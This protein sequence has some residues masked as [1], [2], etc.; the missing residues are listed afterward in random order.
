MG[1]SRPD[2]DYP[3][4]IAELR[5]KAVRIGAELAAMKPPP[6]LAKT[7]QRANAVRRALHQI[8]HHNTSVAI[9]GGFN[10]GKTLVVS[11][12]LGLSELL[13]VRA[14]AAT[15]NITRMRLRPGA[16]PAITYA[17]ITLMP[18]EIVAEMVE[19]VIAG[20]TD[21]VGTLPAYAALRALRGTPIVDVDDPAETDWS[22]LESALAQA[23][24]APATSPA[25]RNATVELL[26]IRNALRVAGR[27][28][29][30]R[31]PGAE[32][33]IGLN[34]LPAALLIE[35]SRDISDDPLGA[36]APHE[37]IGGAQLSSEAG[38]RAVFPLIHEVVVDVVVDP[39]VWSIAD[40][41]TDLLDLPGAGAS[42]KHDDFLIDLAIAQATVVAFM[43]DAEN[44]QSDRVV[45]IHHALEKGRRDRRA[46][47]ASALVLANR[48]DRVNPPVQPMNSAAQ[49]GAH[50][51]VARVLAQVDALAGQ[52]YE[53]LV[54]LSALGAAGERGQT[55]PGAKAKDQND[56][57]RQRWAHALA[58]LP[59]ASEGDHPVPALRGYIADYGVR[60]ARNLITEHLLRHGHPIVLAEARAAE[61]ELDELMRLLGPPARPAAADERERIHTLVSALSRVMHH[62]RDGVD[63][64][65][66]LSGLTTADADG[67]SVPLDDA[68]RARAAQL[69]HGW[70]LWQETIRVAADPT[71]HT[72][73][74]KSGAFDDWL[75]IENEIADER[76]DS[77]DSVAL[78]TRP[79]L[80][81]YRDSAAALA[82]EVDTLLGAAL[83]AWLDEVRTAEAVRVAADRYGSADAPSE[84]RRLLERR[85]GSISS[86]DLVRKRL[87]VVDRVFTGPS[88]VELTPAQRPTRDENHDPAHPN[89]ALPWHPDLPAAEAGGL[90]ELAHPFTA[91][92]I[93]HDF[94]AA[95]HRDACRY[96]QQTLDRVC[97]EVRGRAESIDKVIL[98]S[99][100]EQQRMNGDQR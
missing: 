82:G 13:P 86:L 79:L 61:A 76:G 72:P 84:D 3:A 26:G 89:R 85:W 21:E 44:P 43:V 8:T 19:Y 55:V 83:T 70:P 16:T 9:A 81:H 95:L 51:G 48:F 40:T 17:A 98:P 77:H 93:R 27:Q 73:P 38:L 12:L 78:T 63:D 60:T 91:L 92:R 30:R 66:L 62:I 2:E 68:L 24:R 88:L 53:R 10:I 54:L 57:S 100:A 5:A 59:A 1:N 41:G 99:A 28:L 69:V 46:V 11:E 25:I 34:L 45:R 58:H 97:A 39:R 64:I 50:E 22:A 20:V 94:V 14:E 42:S 4:T 18:V 29:P 33:P 67:A 36:A 87:A 71:A 23:W 7:F 6:H 31:L 56:D 90:A 49:L 74:P 65:R 47:A 96:A 35:D 37:E 32:I 80:V 75:G 15:G 52:H